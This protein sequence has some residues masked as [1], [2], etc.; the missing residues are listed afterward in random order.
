MERKVTASEYEKHKEKMESLGLDPSDPAP[1]EAFLGEDGVQVPTSRAPA[2]SSTSGAGGTGGGGAAGGGATAARFAGTNLPSSTAVSGAEANATFGGSKKVQTRPEP[3][4]VSLQRRTICEQVGAGRHERALAR[5]QEQQERWDK[6]AT[7]AA[8][9]TGREKEQ[10]ALHRAEEHRERL[11]VMELLDRATPEEVKS[12]G[13]SWYHSLRGE[14]TRYVQIGNMF[15]GLYLPVKMHKEIYEHEIVRKPMLRDLVLSRVD[16][17]GERKGPRTWRDDEYLLQRMRRFRVQMEE[18]APGKLGHHELLEIVASP[19][20]RDAEAGGAGATALNNIR[21]GNEEVGYTSEDNQEEWQQPL[22]EAGEIGDGGRAALLAGPHF[23]ASPDRLQFQAG[24]RRLCTRSISLKNTGTASISFEWVPDTPQHNYQESILP[25]DKTDRF[26]C[27][28]TGGKVLPGRETTTMFTFNSSM[29][30]VFTTSWSLKTSPELL[31]PIVGVLMHGVAT[32]PDL[33]QERREF[34]QGNMRKQQVLHQIQELVED[35]VDSVKLQQPP[36]PDI[37]D[38]RVQDRLF[39]DHNAQMGL[40]F[41]PHAWQEFLDLQQR[42]ESARPSAPSTKPGATAVGAGVAAALPWGPTSAGRGRVPCRKPDPEVI[43]NYISK[44]SNFGVPNARQMLD[45]LAI[46]SSSS[47][48]DASK[49]KQQELAVDTNKAIRAAQ[50]TPLERSPIWWMAYE[51]ITEIVRSIPGKVKSTRRMYSLQEWPFIPP[52][53]DNA[54]PEEEAAYQEKLEQRQANR[55]EEERENEWRAKFLEK[56]GTDCFG[57]HLDKFERLA[58]GASVLSRLRSTAS[59]S[60]RERFQ[61]YLDRQSVE[62]IEMGGTVVVYELDLGFLVPRLAAAA[63]LPNGAAEAAVQNVLTLEDGDDREFAKQRLQ[64]VLALLESSPLAVLVVAHLGRPSPDAEQPPQVEAGDGAEVLENASGEEADAGSN[65]MLHGVA[66]RMRSLPSLEQ[67]LE[68]LREVVEGPASSI[69]FVP[70][71]VWLG[72]PETFAEKVRNDRSENKVF[73]MENL[74]VFPEEVGEQ[75]IVKALPTTEE[76]PPAATPEGAPAAPTTMMSFTRVPWARREFWA[77]R[78]FNFLLPDIVVQDSFTTACKSMTLH[79]GFW[80]AHPQRY[81]GPYIEAEMVAFLDVLQLPFKG[82]ESGGGEEEPGANKDDDENGGE[83]VPAP[84][85]VVIGGGG[86]SG[87]S[88]E[89]VL[90]RKLELLIGLSR[91]ARHEPDGLTIAL[92]GEL[93]VAVLACVVQLQMG[94]VGAYA[95]KDATRLAVAEA[96]LEVFRDG[97]VSVQVPVDVVCQEVRLEPKEE[98][99]PPEDP[100]DKKK[101]KPGKESPPPPPMEP[102]PLAQQTFSLGQALAQAAQRPIS[103][104]YSSGQECFL[105]VDP[106]RGLLTSARGE[107]PMPPAVPATPEPTEA[108]EGGDVAPADA[109]PPPSAPKDGIPAGW[110]VRDIGTQSMAGLHLALRRSKGVVWNGALGLLEEEVFRAGTRSFLSAVESR[111]AGDEED[112]EGAAAGDEPVQA[113]GDD[114]DDEDAEEDEEGKSTNE[115][116]DAE[117]EFAVVIGRDSRA[118]LPQLVATPSAISFVSQSGEGLLQ[119]LRGAP[120]PGLLACVEKSKSH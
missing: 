45:Q 54:T 114:D 109:A 81:L 64:G 110:V 73:L 26:T 23:E 63:A 50:Q 34:F 70:H 3:K 67:L 9:K 60:L 57:P 18:K 49:L 14:G 38:V 43:V 91:L 47:T 53:P 103:L 30:G 42:F 37:H 16:E 25:D 7:H 44:P 116:E 62:S 95:T 90:L 11:E 117:F 86:F 68:L 32:E 93:A 107:P 4:R 113:R 85:L 28:Q 51:T 87:A 17:N 97:E 104:G 20:R 106:V 112:E 99:P 21:E 40:H 39:Q 36:L 78:A 74:S 88:G 120:L 56:V 19:M 118:N 115:P 105:S 111:L 5:F 52:P 27:N 31:E 69:E 92:G 15:S 29:P 82:G 79:T 33:L 8:A 41:T 48:S 80:P 58:D 98:A 12:G 2:T 100:K 94:A 6:F 84:L 83:R 71:D 75:R 101:A 89:E 24:V 66:K 55:G 102:T 119:L 22:S 76:A 65:L 59:L 1:C 108:N 13:H 77:K 35:I 61:T 10:L 46:G 96:I 72:E